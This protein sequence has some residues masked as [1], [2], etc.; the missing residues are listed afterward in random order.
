MMLVGSAI[1][2][3]KEVIMMPL[4]SIDQAREKI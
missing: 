4:I 2:K 3:G 1:L